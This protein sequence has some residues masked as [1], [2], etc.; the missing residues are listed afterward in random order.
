[1]KKNDLFI[2]FTNGM[3]KNLQANLRYWFQRNQLL[4]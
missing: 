3:E 4:D 2:Y 1:M